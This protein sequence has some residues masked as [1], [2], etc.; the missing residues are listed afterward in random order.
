MSILQFV[1][2]VLATA[3]YRLS[4]DGG[5]RFYLIRWSGLLNFTLAFFGFCLLWSECLQISGAWFDE[6]SILWSSTLD[7][8]WTFGIDGIRMGLLL[9]TAFI[10]PICMLSVWEN[11]EF[12]FDSVVNCL[13][14]IHLCL[15]AAFVVTDLFLFYIAFETVLIPMFLLIGVWGSRVE[16]IKAAYY[17]FFFTLVGSILLLVA[18]IMVYTRTGTTNVF[19]IALSSELQML[20]WLPVFISFAVKMPIFPMHIWLP[21]A[22]VEAPTAGSVILAALLLKL[23]AYGFIRYMLTVFTDPTVNAFY[24]PVIVSLGMSG[25]I[26]ASLTALRQLDIK[27][28]VAYSSVAHMNLVLIGIFALNFEGL[29]G[30]YMMMIGHGFVSAGMFLSIGIIYD[31][32]HS[33]LIKNYGGLVQLMPL[34]ALLFLMLSFANMGFPGSYNFVGE[35]LIITG[36]FKLSFW[37][38]FFAATGMLLSGLY[39]IWLLNRVVFGDLNITFLTR[40]YDVDGREFIMLGSLVLVTILYGVAP[41]MIDSLVIDSLKEVLALHH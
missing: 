38:G 10:M 28:I 8:Y 16:R 7:W 1:G 36:A 22:H 18:I 12:A 4:V 6:V 41:T 40:F 35:L 39:S 3:L 19:D 33:R 17:F 37:I 13:V 30:A 24:W 15:T 26:F 9:L 14:A 27:R 20:L 31:R 29:H 32:Y 21:E 25:I 5:A 34:F 23:G 2:A 11:T